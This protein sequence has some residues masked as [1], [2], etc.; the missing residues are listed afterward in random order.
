MQ[1]I[2]C[3]EE[4]DELKKHLQRGVDIGAL[5]RYDLDYRMLL[6]ASL[7]RWLA[8]KSPVYSVSNKIYRERREHDGRESGD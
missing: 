1:T 6:W 8:G 4:L 2:L 5:M 7:G 3:Q